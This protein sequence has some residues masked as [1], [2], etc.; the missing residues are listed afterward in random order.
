M[1]C[2]IGQTM[3]KELAVDYYNYKAELNDIALVNYN[4]LI[5]YISSGGTSS[6]DTSWVDP[7][8]ALTLKVNTN[9][10]E[11]FG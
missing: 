2:L 7:F 5:T 8:N 3:K 4:D 10:S 11:F 9:Y 1:I 6:T